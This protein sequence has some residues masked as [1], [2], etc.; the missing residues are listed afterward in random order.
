MFDRGY[1]TPS[2]DVEAMKWYGKAAEAGNHRG[3]L[4]LGQMLENSQNF[5]EARKQYQAAVAEG[6]SDVMVA[7]ARIESLTTKSKKTPMMRPKG[8]FAKQ[9]TSV[10]Q[11]PCFG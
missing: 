9:Q 8:G 2:D 4:M 7:I 1:G 6:N 11:M 3:A 10:I 5:G